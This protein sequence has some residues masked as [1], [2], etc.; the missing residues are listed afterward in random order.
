MSGGNAKVRKK[1][2]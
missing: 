2:G 1:A